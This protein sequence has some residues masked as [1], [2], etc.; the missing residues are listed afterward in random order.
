MVNTASAS[1]WSFECEHCHNVR[2]G[3]DRFC[4][5]CWHPRGLETPTVRRA[6]LPNERTALEMRYKKAIELAREEG[7]DGVVSLFERHIKERTKAVVAMRFEHFELLANSENA[8][9]KNYYDLVD[10]EEERTPAEPDDDAERRITD[11]LLWGRAGEEVFMAALCL[12]P[13]GLRSYGDTYLTLSE[14]CFAYRSVVL[15]ENSF[16]FVK[17]HAIEKPFSGP[18]GYLS[19]WEDR[20]MLA[21]AKHGVDLRKDTRETDFRSILLKSEGLRATDEFMEITI[22]GKFTRYSIESKCFDDRI[23]TKAWEENRIKRIRALRRKAIEQQEEE[24]G[25]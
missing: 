9:F 17:R 19:I 25:T 15:E 13:I 21:V 4:Y 1:G 22:Y 6:R 23:F 24:T 7:R 14:K 2:R 16:H 12:T 11:I 20:H 8:L 18:P 5:A 3:A 10:E